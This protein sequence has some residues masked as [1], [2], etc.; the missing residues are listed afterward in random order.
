MKRPLILVNRHS[1]MTGGKLDVAH[2]R[3]PQ[4]HRGIAGT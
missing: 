4:T 3:L 1:D 2:L